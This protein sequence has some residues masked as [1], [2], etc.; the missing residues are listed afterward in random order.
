MIKG[1]ERAAPMLKVSLRGSR[2][3]AR[4]GLELLHEHVKNYRTVFHTVAPGTEL[5]GVLIRATTIGGANAGVSTSLLD[6][7][8]LVSRRRRRSGR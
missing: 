6:R 2:S 7:G 8:T 5:N 3:P 1:I 4:R